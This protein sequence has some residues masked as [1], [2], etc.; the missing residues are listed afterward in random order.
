[1]DLRPESV[2]PTIAGFVLFRRRPPRLPGW[3]VLDA[4][5]GGSAISA[6]PLPGPFSRIRGPG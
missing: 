6:G 4:L 5:A 3:S 2:M 1:M